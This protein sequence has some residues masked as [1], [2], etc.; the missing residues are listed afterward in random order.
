MHLAWNESLELLQWSYAKY[1]YQ[2]GSRVPAYACFELYNHGVFTPSTVN[3]QT[4]MP[5][6]PQAPHC[7]VPGTTGVVYYV[8]TV[9]VGVLAPVGTM[10]YGNV[11]IMGSV[12]IDYYA[13]GSGPSLSGSHV[14]GRALDG[15]QYS[16]CGGSFLFNDVPRGTAGYATAQIVFTCNGLG[17]QDVN[18]DFRVNGQN[19]PFCGFVRKDGNSPWMALC[20]PSSA[21]LT[22]RTTSFLLLGGLGRR[23]PPLV[24]LSLSISSLGFA[25]GGLP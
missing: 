7:N 25:A 6:A 4:L 15:N 8:Q 22:Q 17:N 24:P 12:D 1:C 18:I 10:P 19:I 11:K 21:G 16:G 5:P 9:P 23:A 14:Q 3:F 2:G 20:S 13:V